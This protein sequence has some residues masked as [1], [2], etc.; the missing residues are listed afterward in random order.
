LT[1]CPKGIA[2][3]LRRCSNNNA[4]PDIASVYILAHDGPHAVLEY[5]VILDDPLKSAPDA[6][7]EV[8]FRFQFTDGDQ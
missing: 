7:Q 8:A 1:Q 5:F 3:R 6:F 2:E 4:D